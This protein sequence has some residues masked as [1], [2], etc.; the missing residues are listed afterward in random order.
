MHRLPVL[1]GQSLGYDDDGKFV[2]L[3][4]ATHQE[5]AQHE[6]QMAERHSSFPQERT[7]EE[8]IPST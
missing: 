8:R 3:L 2:E 5:R 7:S 1:V 6:H 4:L